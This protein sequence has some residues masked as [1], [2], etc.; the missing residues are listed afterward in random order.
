L[1]PTPPKIKVKVRPYA[2]TGQA[3]KKK[4]EVPPS[5]PPQPKRKKG[6]IRRIGELISSDIRNLPDKI[7]G[8]KQNKVKMPESNESWKDWEGE[9]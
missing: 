4:E 6:L 2:P 8:K 9:L 1:T 3:S 5:S 7:W